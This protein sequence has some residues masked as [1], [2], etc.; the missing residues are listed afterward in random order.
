MSMKAV[1]RPRCSIKGLA[2]VALMFG[3]P[4]GVFAQNNSFATVIQNN[5]T[6]QSNLTKQMINLNGIGS[7]T[8]RTS[9]APASC[10]PP[11]ELQRGPS[12]VVPPELQGDP[13]YQ[14]YV[15]CR[16][17]QPNPQSARPRPGATSYQAAQHLPLA[18]TDF[19]PA[20]NGHPAVDRAISG[21]P[22]APQQR[23]QLRDAVELMFN[24]VAVE[25]RG[26]NIAISVTV[27]Y[28]MALL[29]LN[30]AELN[31]QQT[32]EFAFSV[33]DNLAQRPQFAMMSSTEKQNQS[34]SL[35]FQAVMIAVLRDLG[36]RDPQ[37][38]RQAIELSRVVLQSLTQ[39]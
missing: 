39:S 27:A 10:M 15:R 7:S 9:T 21:M 4:V 32:R 20:Q 3:A 38:R 36:R 2:L 14:Q 37:A 35:I 19:V 33:N 6:M 8:S 23:L 13:R 16:Q 22:I 28:S 29:T 24:R 26:N 11:Y 17:G 25:Y 30:G 5:G 1:L 34:D 12:G 31:A 18:A